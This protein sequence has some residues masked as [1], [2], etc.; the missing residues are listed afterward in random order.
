MDTPPS[1]D[2]QI[3]GFLVHEAGPRG[4]DSVH[5]TARILLVQPQ[6][7]TCCCAFCNAPRGKKASEN[8]VGSPNF[9]FSDRFPALVDFQVGSRDS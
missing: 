6:L 7:G 5:R 8:Q 9:K 2:G 4:D 1:P 3:K